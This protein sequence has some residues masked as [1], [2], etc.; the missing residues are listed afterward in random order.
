MLWGKG[1]ISPDGAST[2]VAHSRPSGPLPRPY[3][4]ISPWASLSL[5]PLP[6]GRSLAQAHTGGS[7]RLPLCLSL[8]HASRP[9]PLPHPGTHWWIWTPPPWAPSSCGWTGSRTSTTA[10]MTM[11]SC[12][13]RSLVTPRRYFTLLFRIL[14]NQLYVSPYL[15][16]YL[17]PHLTF[18][19]DYSFM[20]A[21][22]AGN[23]ANVP[24]LLSTYCLIY[25]SGVAFYPTSALRNPLCK[26]L[27]SPQPSPPC[28]L[29][30]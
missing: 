7:G 28:N 9:G 8:P 2:H 24:I 19:P 13:Q 20:R 1:E 22:V 10:S 30:S 16:L 18:Y 5:T 12:E 6:L 4:H 26:P 15:A 21:T 3:P 11:L 23:A 27:S 14:S 17:A 29:L 25:L